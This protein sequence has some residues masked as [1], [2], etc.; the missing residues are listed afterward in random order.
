MASF[1]SAM[2]EV[3][4]HLDL[5]ALPPDLMTLTTSTEVDGVIRD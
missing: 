2:E 3:A 4:Q 1:L 5:V